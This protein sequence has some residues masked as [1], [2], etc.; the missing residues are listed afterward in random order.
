MIEHSGTVIEG[1]RS[2]DRKSPALRCSLSSASFLLNFNLMLRHNLLTIFRSFLRFRSTS[3]IN[4]LGLSTG[5]ASALLIYL[6]V[7]DELSIDKFHENDHR[8]YQV[9]EN[10]MI[11]GEIKTDYLTS[12]PI[13]NA[14]V[15]EMPEVEYAIATAPPTWRGFDRLILSIGEKD[16]IAHGQ[17]AEK[18]YFNVFSYALI[19]GTPDQ[20]LADKNSI[21]ISDE[22]ALRLFNTTQDVIGKAVEFQHEKEFLVTGMFKKVPSRS[23]F[24][25]DF[26]L[27]F[28]VFEEIAPVFKQW[29]VTGPRV[30]VVLRDGTDVN[31]FNKK[32]AGL[33][34]QKTNGSVTFRTPFLARY[35]DFYLYGN[36]H[37]GV[38]SGGRID[39]VRLFAV[40]GLFILAI[41]CINF[42]N[43]STARAAART[44]EVGVKKALGAG[45]RRLTIQYLGESLVMAI[46]SLFM[47]IVLV[48]LILP[49]FNVITAKQL[50]LTF[51]LR[52]LVYLFVIVLFTGLIAGSYPALYL[53]GF[54]PVEV[55]K[56]KLA[57][58]MSEVW[59][60]KGL[61]V[62]QFTL[63]IVLIVSVL[64]VSRQLAFVQTKN[65]GYN[66]ENVI[67]FGVKGR[68]AQ[69][70][71]TFLS[72]IKRIPGVISAASTTHS[73]IGR[74]W[75]NMLDWEGKDPDNSIH[76]ETMGVSPDFLETLGM[77]MKMGRF[78]SN[79]IGADTNR[80]VLNEAA[81]KIMEYKDPVGKVADGMEIIG[82]VRNFH[83]KSLHEEVGPQYFIL[84]RKAYAAPKYI[85]TRIEAGREQETLE[86]IGKF[87]SDFNPGFPF[88][89][90]F[91]D[92]EY[93]A[94]YVAEQRVSILSRYFAGLAI[95]I[96]CL[97]LFGLAAF[98][99]RRR[100]KEIGVRK[101]LGATN[102]R[103]V[104][105]LT[106]D[107]TKIVVIAILIGLP[108][109]YYIAV[110]WLEKFAYKIDLKWWFFGSAALAAL[111]T[112]WFTVALQIVNAARIS[113]SE[114][115]K[116]E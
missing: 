78:F 36:Y 55:L 7:D 99:A 71:E 1:V 111:L 43:L 12:G 41:A 57:T 85:M 50:S 4:L 30:Y 56:G 23:S 37:N 112:A 38:E 2:S 17:Y 5:L 61:V 65:L 34:T 42:M 107:F 108:I 15:K 20:V 90:K 51:N 96:S 100:I 77:E 58:S 40:I 68:I 62:F 32:I 54:K 105:L 53:S 64:V 93:Q 16:I 46:L 60:R 69:H 19:A 86:R 29:D 13:A 94:Q 9:L 110:E 8:L 25:F 102:Y 18:D 72:E 109:S 21:V 92:A 10:H 81:I 76:F 73:M 70:I 22:L 67:C 52:L 113:L 3:I 14:L 82:V 11:N 27:P 84:H 103:I 26:I 66:K 48:S 115:L 89:F 59:I 116:E 79:N 24:Q 39:Y 97:G 49:L 47:A 87:C 63:S 98:T 80:I 114:C 35:S 28:E 33:I 95:L 106:S 31:E 44:R 88:I 104:R 101:I 6:W 45:R 91:L 75:A 83:F 74:N